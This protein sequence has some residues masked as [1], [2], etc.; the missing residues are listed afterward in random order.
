MV[1]T[2]YI[3]IDIWSLFGHWSTALVD[4]F[5][6]FLAIYIDFHLSGRRVEQLVRLCV[7]DRPRPVEY[8][9]LLTVV[10]QVQAIWGAV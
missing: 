4:F 2:T 1:K 5:N 8:Y 6:S 7:I 10:L 9:H 3:L